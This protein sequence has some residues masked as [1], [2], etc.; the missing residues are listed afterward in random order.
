M[1]SVGR[2]LHCKRQSFRGM[3]WGRGLVGATSLCDF[4]KYLQTRKELSDIA[5]ISTVVP[6]R[7]VAA[8][9]SFFGRHW[10]KP[11]ESISPAVF[12]FCGV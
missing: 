3:K 8:L 12:S 9:E 5:A 1:L 2:E 7:A 4:G 11:I 6:E 10:I